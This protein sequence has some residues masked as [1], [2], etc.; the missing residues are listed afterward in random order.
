MSDRGL[1]PERTALAWQR[2]G[3]AAA[4]VAVL[5]VRDGVVHGSAWGIAA[6]ACAA[7]AVPL[8]ALAARATPSAWTRLTLVTGAVVASGLCTVVHLL[9]HY[10]G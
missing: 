2:T 4:V 8:S 9:L 10:D 7:L 3:L 5:L 6:G 1:Q